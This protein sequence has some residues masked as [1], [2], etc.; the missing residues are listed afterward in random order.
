MIASFEVSRLEQLSNILG[1]TSSGL[2]GG[3]IGRYLAECGIRD[4]DPRM[5]KRTR[6]FAALCQKQET[7]G[8]ANNV[9]AFIQRVMSPVL[10]V[11]S[12][13]YFD[14]VQAAL[15]GVLAFEGLRLN[16][17]GKIVQATR[18]T[19]IPEAEAAAS[20]L[21]RALLARAVHSDVLRFCRPELV[22]ENYFHAVLEACK[23]VAEKIREK[24]G[25]TQDGAKLVDAAFGK[26]LRPLPVLAFNSLRTDSERSEHSGLMNLVKG[27]F[28]AFRN[29]TAHAPK[30][31][32]QLAEQDAL[33]ML[34]LA[35]LL[36]RKL[37]QAVRTG[38]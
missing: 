3:E 26:G 8:C 12:P 24:S 10:H 30:I 6:L 2:T 37:D 22:Q 9:C 38:A 13:G 5:T 21:R 1:D 32:W 31:L 23:S 20:R 27:F 29:P 18:F 15:N 28:G 14:S 11:N 35:S 33:D 17:E 7:D 34:T 36:H 4:P 25:L 19:T 16:D